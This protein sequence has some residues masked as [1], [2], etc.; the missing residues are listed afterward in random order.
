MYYFTCVCFKSTRYDN[1]AP[2]NDNAEK[3]AL[4]DENDDL[5]LDL[6]HQHIAIVSQ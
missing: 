5:W 3:E 4:L 1:P 6:R 2:G